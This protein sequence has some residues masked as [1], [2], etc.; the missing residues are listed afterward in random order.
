MVLAISLTIFS[1]GS[2][3]V[4]P[5]RWN[6]PAHLNLGFVVTAYVIPLL[7]TDTLSQYPRDLLELYGALIGVSAGFY[8]IGMVCGSALP[9]MKLSRRPFTFTSL[10]EPELIAFVSRRAIW[11]GWFS[12]AGMIVSYY[13]MGYVPMFASEPAMAKYLRGTYEDSYRQV[14]LLLRSSEEIIIVTLPIMLVL[15]YVTRRWLFVLIGLLQLVLQALTL[16]REMFGLPLLIGI[17][18]I[19]VSRGYKTFAAYLAF[20]IFAVAAASAT[21]YYAARFLDPE[22]TGTGE[23]TVWESIASGAP[24]IPTTL[25]FMS[26]FEIR[27]NL[28]YGRT[29]VGG[30]IPFHYR[31][32]PG[33]WSLQVV[34]SDDNMNINEVISGGLRLPP[35]VMGY[36]AFG[37]PGAILVCLLSGLAVGYGAVFARAHIGVGSLV[38]SAIALALYDTAVLQFVQFYSISIYDV[39][40]IFV[41]LIFAYPVNVRPSATASGDAP[42]A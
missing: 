27:P 42:L 3:L 21:T 2:Y 4:W 5:S 16:D 23:G 12:I 32:Q 20:V 33:V 28:T 35:P 7:M 39:F 17:G 15:Y 9:R 18:L 1:I 10:S 19:A 37:W 25:D 34:S 31:W 38:R 22:F 6:I 41:A 26:A 8:V 40:A 11:L 30:L 29:F 14:A 13:V 24:D 36:T